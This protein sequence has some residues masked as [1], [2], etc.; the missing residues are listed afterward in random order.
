M[1]MEARRLNENIVDTCRS[2]VTWP[3]SSNTS[4]FEVAPDPCF[5]RC[6]YYCSVLSCDIDVVCLYPASTLN[7]EAAYFFEI[8]VPTFQTT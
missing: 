6:I 7:M 4:A 1:I 2:R 8:L 5:V 3:I